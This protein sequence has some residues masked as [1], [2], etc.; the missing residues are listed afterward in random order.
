VGGDWV[1]GVEGGWVWPGENRTAED[2]I[3][4][5][6]YDGGSWV[7]NRVG[8]PRVGCSGMD[9]MA[10]GGRLGRVVWTRPGPGRGRSGRLRFEE[11]K[12]WTAEVRGGGRVS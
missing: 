7:V 1:G 2:H 5:D 4:G 11:A 10:W 6:L 12:I 8:W 9:I 3:Y